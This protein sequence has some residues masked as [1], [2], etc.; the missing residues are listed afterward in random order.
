M[1]A[2]RCLFKG[3]FRID[4]FKSDWALTCP[5]SSNRKWESHRAA[6]YHLLSLH[7]KLTIVKSL[8]PSIEC[9]LY[10]DNFVICYRSTFVHIIERHLQR[11]LN[12]LQH[13]VDF[14][15][16]KFSSTKT[17]CVHFCR[18][19]K[20]HPDPQLL[21]SGTPIPVVEQKIPWFNF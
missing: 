14:N 21:L 12:K 17:V 16:F 1:D 10:V 15:G 19:H 20:A 8:S 4:S 6:S 3:F 2:Y 11:S 7:S 18:L 5:T 9:S 13:W